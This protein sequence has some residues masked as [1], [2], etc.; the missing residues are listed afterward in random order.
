MKRVSLS[1]RSGGVLSDWR[2]GRK[3]ASAPFFPSPLVGEG[4]KEACP[5]L[6]GHAAATA[7]ASQL[8]IKSVPPV[9]AAIGNRLWPAY[10]R[11]V[12]SPA[13]RAE[14]I[15]KPK[16]DAMPIRAWTIA[17]SA[18]PTI[19]STAAAWDSSIEDADASRHPSG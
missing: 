16:A 3:V 15:A 2:A 10:C 13:N 6:R 4:K 8:R 9:G 5:Q 7:T 14:A 11:S 19:P 1:K 18:S 17:R 12:R